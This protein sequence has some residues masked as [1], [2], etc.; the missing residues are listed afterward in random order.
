MKTSS[1]N[2]NII[3]AL[4]SFQKEINNPK[5]TAVNPYYS[6][7]YVPL[8]CLLDHVKPLLVKHGLAVMQ[9]PGG[10]GK[11]VSVTT[12]ILHTSGEWLEADPLVLPLAKPDPQGAGSA[13][14]YARRYALSAVLGI[15]SDD[16]DDANIASNPQGGNGQP[17]HAARQQQQAAAS[18]PSEQK[19]LTDAQRRAIFAIAKS[20]DMSED[21]IKS[22]VKKRFSVEGVSNLNCKQA[23]DLIALLNQARAESKP[24]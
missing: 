19:P 24:A 8:S 10:D 9:I 11:T 17:R 5:V 13:I 4:I 20:I 18:V 7:K 16:D 2:K 15:A 12:L 1:E 21:D 23:S 14:T 6:S 22:F 3:N